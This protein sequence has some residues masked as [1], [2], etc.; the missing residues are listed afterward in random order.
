[1]QPW[2]VLTLGAL[3]A[4]LNAACAETALDQSASP[5][6]ENAALVGV[7]GAFRTLACTNLALAAT[8]FDSADRLAPLLA[9]SRQLR[10]SNAWSQFFAGTFVLGGHLRSAQ[11]V[12]A[13]HNPFF[14]V[15]LF[16][17]W[18][19]NDS[20][21]RLAK[22]WFVPD[23]GSTDQ[24]DLQLPNP[25]LAS[26]RLLR[27]ERWF[28]TNYPALSQALPPPAPSPRE[29][30]NA[31]TLVHQR[32]LL[33]HLH[34]ATFKRFNATQDTKPWW[35]YARAIEKGDRSALASLLTHD[36]TVSSDA[37]LTLPHAI[38][39]GMQVGFA[40]TD[41]DRLLMFS[42]HPHFPQF[43]VFSDYTR[44]PAWKLTNSGLFALRP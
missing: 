18:T 37:L 19:F 10:N 26:E 12:Y 40:I 22:V 20:K 21:P 16:T 25:F 44:E 31:T 23:P 27:T 33:A 28:G 5:S 30:T 35:Q 36:M 34:F 15:A 32:L 43:V 8:L 14:D 41:A 39:T 13:L 29:F 42:W 4:L 7:V 2:L 11:P 3:L 1:V 6:R 24:P 9:T 17:S 38:R